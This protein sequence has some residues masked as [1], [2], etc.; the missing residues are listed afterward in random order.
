MNNDDE[1]SD[2]SSETRSTSGSQTGITG[3]D[4]NKRVHGL[5]H[6]FQQF[7]GLFIKRFH[8]YRRDWRMILSLIILPCLF[9][10]TALGFMSIRP[11][12]PDA[13]QLI[14]TPPL[15]GPDKYVFCRDGVKSAESNSLTSH[16]V[17]Q[18]GIGTT[19]MPGMK[20]TYPF[21]CINAD[22]KFHTLANI[23]TSPGS[24]KCEDSQQHCDEAARMWEVPF[25]KTNT[26]DI[27]Q[28]L[29]G[30]DI[31]DFLIKTA[32]QYKEMRYGGWSFE[33]DTESQDTTLKAKVWFNNK[34]HHAMPSFYN[35]F[36]NMLLRSSV[37]PADG[38]PSDYGITLYNHPLSLSK[39]Q[40]NEDTLLESA[41]D[42]GVALVFLVAFTFVPVGIMMYIVN[43]Y[44][45]KEKQLQFVSGVG[46]VMYWVTSFIWDALAF[47]LAVGLAVVIMAIFRGDS[48]WAR[49]NLKAIV[50]L[51]LL[52]GWAT[53]PWM[54]CT[55]KI[56]K[57]ATSAYMVLFTFNMFVGI[58]TMVI[59]FVLNFFQNQ[60][61]LQSS[62]E[63]VKYLFLIFPPYSLGDGLVKII[64][65]QIQANIFSQFGQDVYADPFSFDVLGWHL[66]ALGIEGFVFAVLTLIIELRCS[67]KSRL[68]RSL[69]EEIYKENEEVSN[70]K[71]RVLSG[72]AKNDLLTVSNLSKVY[73][74]SGKEF[75]AVDHLTFG[76]PKAECFGL[77]G[78]NG[79][80]KTTTFRMLTGDILPSY[81]AAYLKG[82]RISRGKSNLGQEVG[83]CPQEDA[84]DMFLTGRE[85]LHCHARLRGLAPEAREQA[86]DAIISKLKMTYADKVIKTYSGGMKRNL[87][88]AISLL[89]EPPVIFMDEP[90]T[91]MD[92]ST[93][94]RDQYQGVLQIDIPKG[95]TNVGNIIYV[96][97]REKQNYHITHYSVSQTTLDNVFLNF[98]R[99]QSDGAKQYDHDSW[100]RMPSGS[101]SNSGSGTYL[102]SPFMNPTYAYM[103]P[104]FDS[105]AYD[106]TKFGSEHPSK[107][108]VGPEHTILTDDKL[109]TKL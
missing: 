47:C 21:K 43:E 108:M 53:L 68:P 83:Y 105:E 69:E 88:V 36:S 15:Y 35:A 65:N 62:Y 30:L 96:L 42:V 3:V 16:L 59:A 8:H 72:Y 31:E 84:L 79:A 39:Q 40:L 17:R 87:M 50:V 74:R 27:L 4:I 103:N 38:D 63:V 48:Y 100:E 60:S 85:L 37:N 56:F 90:T 23:E 20:L 82:H 10:L 51:I 58:T 93:K 9:V 61:S 99:E 19:C 106:K 29:D 95:S 49:D 75:F 14:M 22:T 57:D 91:G 54:Y 94:R 45:R 67:C 41:A 86:V 7:I 11:Q 71:S 32:S 34:G 52:Y 28:K 24:C 104:G 89:G 81:G 70:E 97:E 26:T 6:K 64:T 13:I 98:A 109:I 77:L 80:G 33:P 73:K 46:P 55:V 12:S 107:L 25:R 76:V 78:I 5:S 101:G 102:S 92:P 2:K 44:K 1:L 18:P 66:V